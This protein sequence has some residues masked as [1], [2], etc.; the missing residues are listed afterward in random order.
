MSEAKRE[1]CRQEYV[2]H[3]RHDANRIRHRIDNDRA[4]TGTGQCLDRS[5]SE[6]KLIRQRRV[7]TKRKSKWICIWHHSHTGQGQSCK[8]APPVPM[9]TPVAWT[10]IALTCNQSVNPRPNALMAGGYPNKLTK[11]KWEKKSTMGRQFVERLV[12]RETGCQ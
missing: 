8:H 6:D 5:E 12:K 7:A 2:I 9:I 10:S 11:E 3:L 4:R 1:V